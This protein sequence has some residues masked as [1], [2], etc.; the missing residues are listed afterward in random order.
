MGR[1]SRP[2]FLKS[3]TS[4]FFLV[5]T[6]IAGSPAAW[7]AVTWALICS[8]WALRSGWLVPSRVLLLACRLKPRRFNSRPTSFWPAVKPRSASD[9]DRWRWL[10]LT[11]SK[12]ASGS[13]RMDDCTNS[14]RA[15][16]IPGWVSVAGL[17]PP[18]RRR[19]RVLNITAPERR[20]A[21]PRSIVLRAIPVACDTATTPPRPAARASLAAN[22]RR[23]LSSSAGASASKRALMAAMSI[24]QSG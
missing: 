4:S 6:E 7:K 23:P 5:S 1:N 20:S 19:T 8:N 11:H 24:T 10:L 15:A 16:K 2:P 3:P 22:N 9:A 12:A 13:P 14:F 18:P 17:P 21:R